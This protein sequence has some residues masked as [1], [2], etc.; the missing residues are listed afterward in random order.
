MSFDVWFDWQRSTQKKK[1][2]Q[3]SGFSGSRPRNKGKLWYTPTN[4]VSAQKAKENKQ[5]ESN[6]KMYMYQ[7]IST[8]KAA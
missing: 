7:Y 1:L 8:G 3:S 2:P 6:Q 5:Q 4:T